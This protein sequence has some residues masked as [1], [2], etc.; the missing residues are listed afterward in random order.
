MT[1]NDSIN[2]PNSR[3]LWPSLTDTTNALY[4]SSD[5]VLWA[6]HY[7]KLRRFILAVEEDLLEATA[8]GVGITTVGKGVSLRVS[9]PS[10]LAFYDADAYYGRGFGKKVYLNGNSIPFEFV[11]TTTSGPANSV[12]S[13]PGTNQRLY[14]KASEATF[15]S[16]FGKD[17]FDDDG[18][19]LFHSAGVVVGSAGLGAED[20][21]RPSGMAAVAPYVVM[22]HVQ[23][24]P[25]YKAI[26]VRGLVVDTL[27]SSYSGISVSNFEALTNGF[28]QK[29][30]HFLELTISAVT[31]A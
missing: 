4:P 7:N 15:T 3:T 18:I 2:Y 11:F 29:T 14:V 21:S 31:Y 16:V 30:N 12:K 17:P 24:Y 6:S 13:V 22:S 9:F 23:V 10:L 8:T 26:V 27:N 20:S 28:L 5:N 19:D 1:Y 25:D